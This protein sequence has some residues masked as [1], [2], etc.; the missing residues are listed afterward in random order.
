MKKTLLLALAAM[1]FTACN[2]SEEEELT[3]KMPTNDGSVGVVECPDNN[4]PHAIDLGLPSGTK[5]SCCNLGAKTPQDFGGYYAWGEVLP[6]K[7]FNWATYVHYSYDDRGHVNFTDIGDNIAGTKY[8][9][10]RETWGGHWCMPTLQQVEE[11]KEYCYRMWEL[12]EKD[13]NGKYHGSGAYISSKKN[14]QAKIFFPAGSF[15]SE[16]GLN[17]SNGQACY[18]TADAYH[19]DGE[20]ISRDEALRFNITNQDFEV[21]QRIHTRRDWGLTIRPVAK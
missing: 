10:A 19:E 1:C 14:S 17:D 21:G 12:G 18:W 5:W 20:L 4:H 2:N 8:D 6:K 9:A 7:E 3:P 13:A 16:I 15:Y 11:L